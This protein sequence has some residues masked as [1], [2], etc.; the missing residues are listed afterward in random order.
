[1]AI[2]EGALFPQ[3]RF[4]DKGLGGFDIASSFKGSVMYN[5]P[6]FTMP[7][8]RIANALNGWRI[9]GIISM[10]SGLPINPVIGNR[11]LSNNPGAAGSASD[12]PDLDPSFDR[13]KVITHNP[14][15]WF[16][17]T[18]FDLPLAGTLGNAPRNFLRGP[19]LKNVDFSINKDTRF[20][21][22]GEQGIVQFRADF[23]NIL[24]RP[25]FANP[26]TGAGS[27]AVT[28]QSLSSP[29]AIQCGPNYAVKSCQ[30]GSSPALTFNSIA[31]QITSTVTTSRQIQLSLKLI[32]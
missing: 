29:A 31:G 15:R 11:S 10:Q 4:L 32:F 14:S 7:Q 16:D 22:L 2:G 9:A 27:N 8:G 19:D 23:F 1:M 6:A 13:N 18:M 25:N 24:N 30:F 12:R 5:I 17:P 28:I 26:R 21:A 3:V 20:P